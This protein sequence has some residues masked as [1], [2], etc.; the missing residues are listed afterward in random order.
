MNLDAANSSEFGSNVPV[1][2]DVA[3]TFHLIGK[4]S[5]YEPFSGFSDSNGYRDIMIDEI[6][7]IECNVAGNGE[8]QIT[9]TVPK[10][11]GEK[12]YINKNDVEYLVCN[13]KSI[14]GKVIE[15]Y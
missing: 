4:Y 1:Y 12:N 8:K 15:T 13:I 5:V 3:V 2:D 14:R 6:F 9:K 11:A 7:T 10:Y